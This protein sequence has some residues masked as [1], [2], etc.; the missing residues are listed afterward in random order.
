MIKSNFKGTYMRLKPLGTLHVLLKRHNELYTWKKATTDANNIIMGKIY[1]DH[2]GMISVKNS[3]GE[4]AEI[5]LHKK[6]WF[7]KKSHEVEG[8]IFDMENNLKY[9]ISG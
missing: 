4:H 7:S 5:K 9:T 3:N 2:H 8:K 1:L 6:G